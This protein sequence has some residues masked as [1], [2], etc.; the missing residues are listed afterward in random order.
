LERKYKNN[1][2]SQNLGIGFMIFVERKKVM[3]YDK[4]NSSNR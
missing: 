2:H 1:V 4:D 3:H